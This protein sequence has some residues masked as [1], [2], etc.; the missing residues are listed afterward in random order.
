MPKSVRGGRPPQQQK[1][2]AHGADSD[3]MSLSEENDDDFDE[4]VLDDDENDAT[5]GEKTHEP[6]VKLKTVAA[7]ISPP[8]AMDAAGNAV[9][10]DEEEDEDDD[11]DSDDLSTTSDDDDEDDEE[12]L[13]ESDDE[14]Q[15][16]PAAGVTLDATTARADTATG[17][18]VVGSGSASA[19]LPLP[20]PPPPPPPRKR[21]SSMDSAKQKLAQLRLQVSALKNQAALELAAASAVKGGST[22]K[23]ASGASS[24]K[25]KQ[26]G[27]EQQQHAASSSLPSAT[28]LASARRVGAPLT[29]K[30]KVA[31]S[32]AKAGLA[33][34][35]GAPPLPPNKIVLKKRR[36][37]TKVGAFGCFFLCNQTR[38]N[39]TVILLEKRV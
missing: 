5:E 32:G 28:S 14:Q 13:S 6:F 2:V 30:G 25:R 11:S 33:L 15:S 19:P 27:G 20:P 8:K 22:A 35:E 10:D 34:I 18:E 3:T 29:K 24:T 21:K 31:K 36:V 16:K 38:L 39:V 23:T 26:H 37:D 1:R 12:L 4:S 7:T 17:D 9:D